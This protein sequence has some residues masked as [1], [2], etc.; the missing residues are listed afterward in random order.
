M[1]FRSLGL[2]SEVDVLGGCKQNPSKTHAVALTRDSARSAR[3]RA[4]ARIFTLFATA[5]QNIS[6]RRTIETFKEHRRPSTSKKHHA[7][8]TCF[9]AGRFANDNLLM[10]KS[11]T[12]SFS[13]K[14]F[15]RVAP[16]SPIVVFAIRWKHNSYKKHRQN[17]GPKRG[18]PP[19]H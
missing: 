11:F 17:G 5:F 4:P 15:Q 13:Y 9:H 19:E 12:N 3:A 14:H 16:C 7:H 8:A 6:F 2:Y 1:S 10:P 18:S